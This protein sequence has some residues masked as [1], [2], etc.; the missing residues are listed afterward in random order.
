MPDQNWL[1]ALVPVL[2]MEPQFPTLLTGDDH[3]GSLGSGFGLEV[4]GGSG[5]RE[6]AV[7]LWQRGLWFRAGADRGCAWGEVGALVGGGS[8]RCSPSAETP[9]IGAS[10]PTRSFLCWVCCL[11]SAFL[12]PMQGSQQPNRGGRILLV[13]TVMAAGSEGARTLP[14]ARDG[15]TRLVH[16]L[17]LAVVRQDLCSSG[18]PSSDPGLT[19]AGFQ[20]TSENLGGV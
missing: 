6:A 7:G 20:V 19:L 18:Y 1:L 17:R 11:R 5:R 16:G 15:S 8:V 4:A 13:F 14:E 3:S 10:L 12:A 9:G 2:P